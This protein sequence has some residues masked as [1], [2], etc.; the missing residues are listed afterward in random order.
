MRQVMVKGSKIVLA[1]SGVALLAAL[2]TSAKPA[3]ASPTLAVL[4]GGAVVMG[5]F[6]HQYPKHF[7]NNDSS[8]SQQ[9]FTV[10][11]LTRHDTATQQVPYYQYSQ[12]PAVSPTAPAPLYYYYPVI[13]RPMAVPTYGGYIVTAPPAFHYYAPN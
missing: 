13:A 2:L 12:K 3:N 4:G 7:G 11:P 10:Q 9:P 5:L 1:V 8:S 6:A